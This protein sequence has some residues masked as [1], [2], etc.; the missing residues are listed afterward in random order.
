MYTTLH[1]LTAIVDQKNKKTKQKNKQKNCRRTQLPILPL[2]LP[3]SL[4][5]YHE[6]VK[7]PVVHV[8]VQWIV[9][10]LKHPACTVGWVARLCRIW[11]SPGKAT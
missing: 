7:D 6:H 11:V 2:T 4:S 1:R 5:V 3:P 10:T 9:E 8:R